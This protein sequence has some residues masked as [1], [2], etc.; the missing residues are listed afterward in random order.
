MPHNLPPPKVSVDRLKELFGYDAETGIFVRRISVSGKNGGI[1]NVAGSK[2][3]RGDIL[4]MIDGRLQLAHRLAWLYAFGDLPSEPITHKNGNKSDNR[5]ENLQTGSWREIVKASRG[6]VDHRYLRTLLSYSEETGEFVWLQD[7]NGGQYPAG[8][9]AGYCS[10]KKLGYRIVTV[11]GRRYKEHRLAWFYVH[12][13]WPIND[14]D[15]IDGD[16]SNN[17]L[18]NLREATHA[19]NMANRKLSSDNR[20][21]MKGVYRR[22]HRFGARK[23][24][25][26]KLV[27]LGVYDTP[28]EAHAAY[29]RAAVKMHGQ[30]A[31]FK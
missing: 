29:C 10:D 30:F 12:G 3:A 23:N 27:N 20:V 4:M 22:G 17:R 13:S 16:P 2:T 25:N 18:A 15:H 24:V 1:G 31:R 7:R 21:G 28:E 14:I 11:D 19:Q 9:R 8:T 6:T 5:I 26:G